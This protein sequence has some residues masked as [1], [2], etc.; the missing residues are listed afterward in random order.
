[1]KKLFLFTLILFLSGNIYGQ[2]D[3]MTGPGANGTTTTCDQGPVSYNVGDCDLCE[4][5]S[6]NYAIDGSVDIYPWTN[7]PRTFNTG[8]IAGTV[9]SAS[10]GQITINWDCSDLECCEGLV[11]TTIEY[12]GSEFFNPIIR[13]SCD[14]APSCDPG[15]PA[16]CDDYDLLEC[17]RTECECLQVCVGN[18][19][20]TLNN[21]SG[22]TAIFCFAPGT[23][24]DV[25]P[26]GVDVSCSTAQH[27]PNRD[28]NSGEEETPQYIVIPDVE[29]ISTS[30]ELGNANIQI[31]LPE[32]KKAFELLISD[33]L[34]RVITQKNLGNQH[35][36]IIELNGLTTGI[37]HILLTDG[38]TTITQK[39]FVK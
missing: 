34:G 9:V 28:F 8:S 15:P 21:D 29:V 36:A 37:Y 4:G 23:I 14:P 5:G 10:S 17:I 38:Q 27:E 22:E 7:L 26:C 12:C 33:S 35:Q 31:E 19:L 16:P 6:W 18:V 2:I 32:S 39:I 1:M 25:H 13:L 3:C 11:F 24:G 30:Q 20:V